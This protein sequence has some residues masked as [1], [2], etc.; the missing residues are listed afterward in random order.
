MCLHLFNAIS[1]KMEIK[2]NT[3]SEML[4]K[5]KTILYLAIMKNFSKFCCG[6]GK[7]QFQT[8]TFILTTLPLPLDM[9]V[10]L[11]EHLWT[12]WFSKVACKEAELTVPNASSSTPLLCPV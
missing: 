4:L 5:L 12:F 2:I 11:D 3:S 6:I 1:I 10:V 7:K 8:Y 9:N